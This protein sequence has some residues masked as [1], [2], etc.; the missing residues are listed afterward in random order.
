MNKDVPEELNWVKARAACSLDR[1]F[2]SLHDGIEQD[3]SEA[4]SL[5]PQ[6][7]AKFRMIRADSG[8]AF[9]VRRDENINLI[10]TVT[11]EDE[12]IVVM[13]A[14]GQEQRFKVGLNNEGRCQLRCD[15]RGFEQ[16]QVRKLALEDLL[17]LK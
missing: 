15:G 1:V 9:T 12:A 13:T 11:L 16:W 6:G 7:F 10:V 5:Q 3:L 4:N 17:F 2:V 8:R 14:Q